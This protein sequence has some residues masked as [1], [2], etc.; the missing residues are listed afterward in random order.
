[1]P[2]PTEDQDIARV[3]RCADSLMEFFDS[4]QILCTRHEE[5][6]KSGTIHI[7]IGRGNFFARYGQAI[8]WIEQQKVRPDSER[9]S[10][11]DDK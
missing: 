4:V 3:S 9:G 8:D 10:E 7:H 2:C 11:P 1:M 6:E 5:G